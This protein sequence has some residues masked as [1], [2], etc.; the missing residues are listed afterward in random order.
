MVLQSLGL[1]GL[2]GS[3]STDWKGLDVAMDASAFADELFFF[4]VVAIR[5]ING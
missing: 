2:C 5:S 4:V 3:A 1:H